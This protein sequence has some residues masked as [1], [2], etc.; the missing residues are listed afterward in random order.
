MVRSG[1]EWEQRMDRVLVGFVTRS[2]PTADIGDADGDKLRS[3]GG[4]TDGGVAAP[5]AKV[6]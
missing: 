1:Q 2:D 3:L 4:G 5:K 6:H